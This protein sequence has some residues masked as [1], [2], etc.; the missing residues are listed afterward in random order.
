MQRVKD[1]KNLNKLN[2]RELRHSFSVI[3]ASSVSVSLLINT[4]LFPLW[5]DDYLLWRSHTFYGGMASDLDSSIFQVGQQKYR[6]VF[7][8]AITFLL[9]IFENNPIPFMLINVAL[10]L[11]TGLVLGSIINLQNN[12]LK[13]S[14]IAGL[15]LVSSSRFTWYAT[16]NIYGV[17]ETLS[18]LFVLMFIKTFL[19]ALNQE[20]Y[21][22]YL[23]ASALF[24][25][26][27]YTHERY[28]LVG[29][30]ASIFFFVKNGNNPSKVRFF[31]YLPFLSVITNF[32]IKELVLKVN[33][34][35]GSG[36]NIADSSLSDTALSIAGNLPRSFFVL[37]GFS[38]YGITIWFKI[39]IAMFAFSL[40][41]FIYARITK[42]SLTFNSKETLKDQSFGF[43]VVMLLGSLVPG[44]LENNIQERFL[45]VPYLLGSAALFMFFSRIDQ[46]YVVSKMFITVVLVISIFYIPFR[47]SYN[48][49]ENSA[50]K[51]YEML[52]VELNQESKEPWFLIIQNFGVSLWFI[53]YPINFDPG[54]L[55]QF[56]NPPIIFW[57][58]P[59]LP[60][61]PEKKCL[62]LIVDPLYLPQVQKCP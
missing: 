38:S 2:I 51:V 59:N 17:M 41:I 25:L 29:V 61:D 12:N 27:I 53:G 9:K 52:N 30:F 57:A 46:K 50:R 1:I 43:L 6:P 31:A 8:I 36:T 54:S 60:I 7:Q 47:F 33:I 55:S 49:N 44:I 15:L 40:A 13:L 14:L 48:Y 21:S 37:L 35:Q 62:L 32:L 42:N 26:A 18:T 22:L 5:G 34:L 58:G 56:E 4:K 19:V 10:L 16:A 23:K 11:A 45:L 24:T 20:N 28:I 39:V 3:L